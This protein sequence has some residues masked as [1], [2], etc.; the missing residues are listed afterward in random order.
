MS[1][2]E[3]LNRAIGPE[4]FDGYRSIELVQA[5]MEGRVVGIA[6]PTALGF[7]LGNLC[8]ISGLDPDL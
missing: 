2:R 3:I 8:V 4:H 5:E 7:D 6:A 1:G